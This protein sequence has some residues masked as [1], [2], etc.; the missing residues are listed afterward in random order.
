MANYGT[1]ANNVDAYVKIL[2][3]KAFILEKFLDTDFRSL[4]RFLPES[5]DGFF[6]PPLELFSLERKG[7]PLPDGLFV[8]SVAAL[9]TARVR[10][11]GRHSSAPTSGRSARKSASLPWFSFGKC[12]C[13]P[14]RLRRLTSAIIHLRLMHAARRPSGLARGVSLPK[15]WS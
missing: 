14:N 12:R 5:S 7:R 9:Q 15:L 6:E 8:Y 1:L 13:A 3:T 4:L 10:G 11:F 2:K